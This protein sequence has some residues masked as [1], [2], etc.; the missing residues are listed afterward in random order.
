MWP[1]T[2]II[3][4]N[5]ARHDFLQSMPFASTIPHPN[6]FRINNNLS[7]SPNLKA[8]PSTDDQ[9]R[10]S[11]TYSDQELYD[12][13]N[14]CYPNDANELCQEFQN[15]H[16]TDEIISFLNKSQREQIHQINSFVSMLETRQSNITLNIEDQDQNIFSFDLSNLCH[17]TELQDMILDHYKNNEKLQ[18]KLKSIRLCLKKDD[19][20]HL[21]DSLQG[22]KTLDEYHIKNGQT[23]YIDQCIKLI[24]RYGHRTPYLLS[25]F[26]S[27]K[28]SELKQR[29]SEHFEIPLTQSKHFWLYPDKNEN[30]LLKDDNDTIS[31]SGIENYQT[32][33]VLMYIKLYIEQPHYYI[34]LGQTLRKELCITSSAT[35]ADIKRIL[36]TDNSFDVTSMSFKL[37]KTKDRNGK[38]IGLKENQTLKQLNVSNYTLYISRDITLKI[39]NSDGDGTC[40]SIHDISISLTIEKLKQKICTHFDIYDVGFELRIQKNAYCR[41]SLDKLDF[42]IEQYGIRDQQTLFIEL[43][44]SWKGSVLGQSSFHDLLCEE[45]IDNEKISKGNE[46]FK[47]MKKHWNDTCKSMHKMVSVFKINKNFKRNIDIYN[48][49]IQTSKSQSNQ[50]GLPNERILFHGTS[51]KNLK[52]IIVNGFNRDHNIRSVYGKGTYFSNLASLASQYCQSF[53]P[54][55]INLKVMLVCKVYVGDSTI[56]RRNMDETELYKSDKVT[57]YDSLVDHLTRPRI[58]VINRDYHAVPC[59]VIVFTSKSRYRK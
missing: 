10:L 34:G 42:T 44:D 51:L 22:Y 17:V 11:T 23:L 19:N 8:T 28:L 33:H 7:K 16:N 36:I 47:D 53:G 2:T 20:G 50:N 58:F 37:C 40:D 9:S 18:K 25:V 39:D 52:S 48:A 30:N 45:D 38:W 41:E 27:S 59:F 55:N 14:T 12:I 21:L 46:L 35:I 26:T 13:I 54:D 1:A 4:P 15:Y 49:V 5:F 56:G 24:I 43:S 57:Q 6:Q 32:L 31:K 29:I 3:D